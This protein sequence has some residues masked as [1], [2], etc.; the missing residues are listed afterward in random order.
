[1]DI[2]SMEIWRKVEVE[3]GNLQSGTMVILWKARGKMV[4]SQSSRKFL[5]TYVGRVAWVECAHI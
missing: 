2:I 3:K 5:K 1:M 4:I